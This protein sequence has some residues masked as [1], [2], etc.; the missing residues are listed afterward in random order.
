VNR[1]VNSIGIGVHGVP[2]EFRNSQDRLPNLG[3]AL[4]MIILDLDLERFRD[5]TPRWRARRFGTDDRLYAY[6][7]S[8]SA[9][10]SRR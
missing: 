7:T 3:E 10:S 1:D 2:N 9:C 5:R 8:S 6:H 4:Q